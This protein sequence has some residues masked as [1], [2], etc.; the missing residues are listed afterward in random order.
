MASEVDAV[1][2][3]PEDTNVGKGG[4]NARTRDPPS[5]AWIP[6]ARRRPVARVEKEAKRESV[7]MY[8]QCPQPIA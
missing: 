4:T 7:W 2:A 8:S 5:S 1:I 3:D 6:P